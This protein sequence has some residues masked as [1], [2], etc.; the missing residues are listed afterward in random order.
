MHRAL[1]RV[2]NGSLNKE[3]Q[4]K[5]IKM[6]LIRYELPQLARFDEFDRWIDQSFGNF[7]FWPNLIDRGLRRN[8]LNPVVNLYEDDNNFHARFE[9]PGVKKNEIEVKLENAVL[10]VSG[11]RESSEKG[12]E[13][14]TNFSRSISI[15]DGIQG[16]KIKANYEHG[17]LTVTLPKAELSKPKL[18]E[19]K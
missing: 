1:F 2:S 4:R 10:T 14:K 13:Q 6:K 3:K 9:L 19:V 8:R 7:D 18:I 16:N 5:E 12:S 11:K 17:I 15:P